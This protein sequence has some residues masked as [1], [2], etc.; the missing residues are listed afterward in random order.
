MSLQTSKEEYAQALRMGEKEYN[1]RVAAGKDPDPAVLDELVP[2]IDSL[3]VRDLGLLEIPTERIVGVKSAGRTGALTAGFLPLLPADSEFAQKWT[4]LCSAHLS[5][6]GIREPIECFEYLGNF[7]VQEGNKRVSVLR[8]FGAARIPA[9]V[10]RVMPER[11]EDPRIQAYFE[12]LDFF[13]CTRLYTVQFRRP[14]DYEK[15]LSYLGKK[16]DE[17]WTETERRSFQSKFY[18]FQNAV[19]SVNT[20]NADILTEEALLLWLQLYPFEDLGKL[21]DGELKKTVSELWDDVLTVQGDSVLVETQMD[22][23]SK[24]GLLTRIISQ[25]P[26][27][28]NLAFV[29]QLDPTQSGWAMGHARGIEH[30]KEVLGDKITVR[31]Y[32]NANTTAEVEACLDKAVQEG[33]QVVFTTVPQMSTATLKAAVKH[34]K[35]QFFNCSVDRPYS[36]IRTYYGRVFEAKF[37]TGAIA[38]AMAENDR[39]G[40]IASYP[41]YGVPASINAFALGAQMTNPRAKIELR[42]SCVAGTHQADFL[43]DGIRVVS[44]RDVPVQSKVYL[45]FCNYGTYRMDAQGELVPLASPV[46]VWGKFYEKAVRGILNGNLK[47]DKSTQARNY[48]L[49][50]DSGVIDIDLSDKLPDGVRTLALLLRKEIAEKT[51]DPF[52]RVITDQNGTLR[53][54]DGQT[55]FTMDELIHMDWLCENVIGSIPEYDQILPMS[56][57]MVRELGIYKNRIP[58]KKEIPADEDTNRVG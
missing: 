6:T 42:W 57:T 9:M 17:V 35:V 3:T 25:V 38:G 1:E 13:K 51:L 41:I 4:A 21:S 20:K 22:E 15:L 26:E 28:L 24:P 33:A 7:Y 10:K 11:S 8:Y 46:W 54:P 32:E 36:S 18:L 34:P 44:N 14:K 45:D 16:P 2:D 50:M 39:I 47:N 30:L 5:D 49:G 27:H 52:A 29:Q 40:Y 12:F 37:I 31:C 48:W 43:A 23:G 19:A 56:D 58:V 55:G 53:N